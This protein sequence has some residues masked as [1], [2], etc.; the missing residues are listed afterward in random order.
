MLNVDVRDSGIGI[1]EEKM[2]MIFEKFTQIDSSF[3]KKI[4]RNGTW[5]F[6]NKKTG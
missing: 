5:S 3:R 6:D 4:Q 1:P 2:D